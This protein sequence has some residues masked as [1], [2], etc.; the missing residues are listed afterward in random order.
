MTKLKALTIP[1]RNL[2]G[3]DKQLAVEAKHSEAK[4]AYLIEAQRR[5][6]EAVIARRD[7]RQHEKELN[8]IH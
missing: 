6:E 7:A 8:G 5:K 1:A 2:N 3:G 4:D